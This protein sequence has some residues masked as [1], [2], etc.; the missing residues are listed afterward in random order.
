[1]SEFPGKAVIAGVDGMTSSLTAVRW[2]AAEARRRRVE[3]RL[4]HAFD[5]DSLEYPQPLP[6]REELADMARIRGQRLLRK[7]REIARE[8]A[9]SVETQLILRYE[10][11]AQAL[12]TMSEDAGL[13]VLG[14]EEIRPLGRMLVG[15]VSIG[16]AAHA[17]CPI[18]VVRPH[19]AEEEAPT[20]GAVVVG[21]DGTRTSEAALA[22]AFEEASW[23]RAPLVAVHTWDDAFLS[24]L[25]E[26]ARWTLDAREIEERE[27]EVLAERL[28]GWQEKYPDVA[29]DRVVVR[30]RP[31]DELL[32]HADRAQLLVVGSRGRGGV[33]GMLL[34]STSQHV[35]S[36]ALCPVIVARSQGEGKP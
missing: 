14:P 12:L 23:R 2:A 33:A 7:A 17:K 5:K 9:P 31:A 13:L 16:L 34:G 1:M 4:V 18:A 11:P 6:T 25:F 24:A 15:S 30:G 21:I 35:L 8:A 22:L 10:K 19:A 27:S 26:E 29:V 28:A 36:Y 20:E 3:L 32:R